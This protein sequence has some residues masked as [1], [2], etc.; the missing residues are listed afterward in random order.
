MR[1]QGPD[2]GARRDEYCDRVF[3]R[4]H[5]RR[6]ELWK[7]RGHACLRLFDGETLLIE[8]PLLEG[9]VWAQ[10]LALRTWS[11]SRRRHEFGVRERS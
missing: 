8:E 3:W 7:V 2:N 6:C 5:N 9:A 1:V 10:A 4:E 11:P